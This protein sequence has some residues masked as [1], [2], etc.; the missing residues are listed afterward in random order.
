VAVEAEP[1]G[2]G[3]GVLALLGRLTLHYDGP[4]P[5]APRT[6]VAKIPSPDPATRQLAH[7]LFHFYEREVAFYQQLAGH[8][9]I[10][11][12]ACYFSAMDHASG[13]FVLLLEDLGEMR[14]GNQIG[15]CSAEDLG[16][17]I[18]AMARHH[19]AWWNSP[20]LDDLAWLP[21]T[22]DPITKGGLALYRQIWP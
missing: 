3:M 22:N 16:V 19:A 7:D 10:S 18:L 20:R 5:G 14:L 8:G 2:L 6:L 15:G 1:I 12:P 9:S 11:T 21:P 13:D 4:A 17:L